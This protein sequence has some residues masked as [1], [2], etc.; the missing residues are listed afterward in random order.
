MSRGKQDL[1]EILYEEHV[2][3]DQDE[4]LEE[5]EISEESYTSDMDDDPLGSICDMPE[6]EAERYRKAGR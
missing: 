4:D 5:C 6:E 3:D 2:E 1:D